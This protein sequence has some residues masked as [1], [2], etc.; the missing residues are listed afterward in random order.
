MTLEDYLR[1]HAQNIPDK[2]AIVCGS[3]QVTYGQLWK[4]IV[5]CAEQ[6]RNDGLESHRPY[7]F[8]ATQDARFVVTYCAIHLL[9][10]IAV[11]LEHSA[12]DEVFQKV[13][14]EVEACQFAD[15]IC[16]TLYTTGTSTQRSVVT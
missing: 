7:V 8:R 12:S 14:D 3:H 4:D 13:K 15:D 16:D 10:A 11:P 5:A 2:C 6:L 9:N 1:E